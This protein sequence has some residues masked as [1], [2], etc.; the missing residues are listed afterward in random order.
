M[1]TIYKSSTFAIAQDPVFAREC[2]EAHVKAI[3]SYH[4]TYFAELE[5]QLA[6]MP[7]SELKKALKQVPFHQHVI[8]A[9]PINALCIKTEKMI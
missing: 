5:L 9:T 8:N 6:S 1:A 7:D 2:V 3:V 4:Q